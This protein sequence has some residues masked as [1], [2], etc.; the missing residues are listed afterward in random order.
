MPKSLSQRHWLILEAFL[1]CGRSATLEQISIKT[2]FA[3]KGILLSLRA[4]PS[5]VKELPLAKH[6]IRRWR[7]TVRKLPRLSDPLWIKL[8]KRRTELI[9]KKLTSRL[10]TYEALELN[11]LQN[12]AGRQ[13]DSSIF[14]GPIMRRLRRIERKYGIR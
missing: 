1:N 5:F 14:Y 6:G 7:L 8:N 12:T 2:G 11:D 3:P 10:S 9:D 13:A 4:L